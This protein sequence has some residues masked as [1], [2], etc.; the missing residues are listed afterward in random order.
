LGS[1]ELSPYSAENFISKFSVASGAEKDMR[2]FAHVSDVSALAHCI[3][4]VLRPD[5]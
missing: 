5:S 3:F 4:C 2:T 1:G